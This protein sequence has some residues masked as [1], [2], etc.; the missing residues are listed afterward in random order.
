MCSPGRGAASTCCH[1]T[2]MVAPQRT[3]RAIA[4]PAEDGRCEK[5]FSVAWLRPSSV[6]YLRRTM[7]TRSILVVDDEP[8]VRVLYELVLVRRGHSV[9][10]ATTV[11]EAL[12]S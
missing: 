3:E 8:A 1:P 12:A 4:S 6:L 10:T 7:T 2:F 11:A 9:R 5:P